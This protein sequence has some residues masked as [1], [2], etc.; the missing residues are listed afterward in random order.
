MQEKGRFSRHPTAMRPAVLRG[1]GRQRRPARSYPR[2][3]LV[4]MRERSGRK[5][6]SPAT[7]RLRV[8]DVYGAAG[9]REKMRRSA[10]GRE[11]S[12]A[13]NEPQR[14][15]EPDARTVPDSRPMYNPRSAARRLYIGA[16]L[17]QR[18]EAAQIGCAVWRV[19]LP[20]GPQRDLFTPAAK[21]GND[22]GDC[23]GEKIVRWAK[24]LVKSWE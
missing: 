19:F 5:F 13:T 7:G 4:V 14:I 24:D 6:I 18:R 16:H 15:F 23:P 1:V 21:A 8:A 11:R 20:R 22:Q 2:K 17:M 10:L 9:G 12:A 3:T